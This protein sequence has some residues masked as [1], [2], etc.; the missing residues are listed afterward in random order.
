MVESHDRLKGKHTV[1]LE[2]SDVG[3]NEALLNQP[4][5]S[6][7]F[8]RGIGKK[9]GAFS[10]ESAQSSGMKSGI[11]PYREF[12]ANYLRDVFCM[13][14][15]W[16]RFRPLVTNFYITKQCNL[17]CR[18]CYPPGDEPE[19]DTAEA[20][21]LL[22]KIRIHNPL[23]NFTGG[24]PLLHPGL[25]ALLHEAKKLQFHPLMLSTNGLLIENILDDLHYVD[26]LVISLDSAGGWHAPSSAWVWADASR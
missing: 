16:R 13:W 23:L 8:L 25:P 1:E 9:D 22:R 4:N 15:N 20:L 19:V 2:S 12:L 11:K 18:Y 6:Q 21:G 26:H 7:G 3:C 14:T 24:E 17:R 10:K 5:S